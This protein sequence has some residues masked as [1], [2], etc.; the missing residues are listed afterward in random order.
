MC[1]EI[2]LDTVVCQQLGVNSLV[3]LIALGVVSGRHGDAMWM[4]APFLLETAE[5]V[6]RMLR[7][8]KMLSEA[9]AW[10][11]FISSLWWRPFAPSS[12]ARALLPTR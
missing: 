4:G 9:A 6:L 10:A 11:A 5:E 7:C 12:L 3:L 2:Q 8:W 1:Q